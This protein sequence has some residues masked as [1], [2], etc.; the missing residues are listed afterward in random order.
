[1]TWLEGTIHH[2]TRQQPPLLSEWCLSTERALN[3]SK[4]YQ[5]LGAAPRQCSQ[6]WFTFRLLPKHRLK[7][8]VRVTL[9]STAGIGLIE[10]LIKIRSHTG[11]FCPRFATCSFW[12]W[13]CPFRGGYFQTFEKGTHCT[14]CHNHQTKAWLQA[15]SASISR[16]SLKN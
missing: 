12:A 7:A 9:F 6:Q 11:V 14:F 1:M 2:R 13:Y 8:Q 3:Q 5:L 10:I 4:A 16:A 15:L